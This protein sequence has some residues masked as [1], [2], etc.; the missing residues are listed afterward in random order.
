M[1]KVGTSPWGIAG[2]KGRC[3][4]QCL[5]N[6]RTHN[7][8]LSFQALSSGQQRVLVCPYDR[9][10]PK[11]RIVTSQAASFVGKRIVVRIDN[12]PAN[13]QYPNG[14]FVQVLGDIGSLDAELDAILVEHDIA[15]CTGPFSKVL[16]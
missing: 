4:K 6:I 11:V 2:R 3:L 12:W 5:K 16:D 1:Q 7:S 9:R 10:I 13:S 8:I 14:H 15:D